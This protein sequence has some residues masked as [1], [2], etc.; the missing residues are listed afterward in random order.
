MS[1]DLLAD[2]PQDEGRHDEMFAAPLEPRAHWQPILQ[3]LA[4]EPAERMR[5]RL[6]TVQRRIRENGV[7]Y[8][9][10][11]DPKGADRPWELDLLPLIISQEEWSGIEAAIA[12]RATLLNAILLDVYGEQRM[13]KEGLL[14]PALVHGHAGFLRPCHRAKQPGGV[15]LHVYAADLARSPDGRW[16]V[17]DDRTQAPSGA[18]YALEN[19]IVISRAFPELFRDL[20]IQ[21]LAS[22]FATLRDSLAHWAPRDATGGALTVLL[23][24]GPLNETYFEHAYLARYLGLPLVEGGDLTVR[25]GCV[26]LKTL[27]GLKRVHAILRR[28]DDDHCDPL[29]LRADSAIGVPGM[30]DAMRRGN[31]LIANALGSNLLESSALLGFLPRLCDRLLGEGLKMPSVATWWCGEPVALKT[32]ADNLERLVVKPAFPQLR[33]EPMFGEDLDERGRRRVTAMLRARPNDYVAQ[34]IVRVSQAPVLDRSHHRRLLAR[35]IGLRVFACASPNGYVVMPGGLT[36]VASAGDARTISMQR[37]GSSKDTWVMAAGPVSTFSL[38]RRSIGPEE[39]VRAGTN[40]SS[41]VV[42]N[43]FWFG[44]YC[45]RCDALARLLRVALGMLVDEMPGDDERVRPIVIELLRQAGILPADEPDPDDVVLAR[46]L[47]AAVSD[48]TRPGLASGLRTLARTASHLRERLSLDNWRT[49]NRMTRGL[50][51]QKGQPRALA[52]LLGELDITIGQFTTL[53]GYAL[54]GMTRDPGWRFLS[55]GRRIERLQSLGA[56]LQQALAN[57]QEIELT[58]LLRL[59]D[60]I[61]TYRARYM[62]RPE[63]LPVLDL[64]VRDEANPRSIAFQ[65]FGLRDFVRRLVEL[66][67]EFGDERFLGPAADLQAIDPAADLKHGSEK[68][69]ALLGEWHDASSRLAEQIGL[70]FFSHVGESSRQTFAT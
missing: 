46:T 37:G 48:E 11:A 20:K 67:G 14:P 3:Q 24:P 1:R 8:N 69:A 2:Y 68:L 44:R 25:D 13:L 65:V 19:R 36:R 58:W 55:I 33:V 10:Y 28:L 41:R 61:I 34:E 63:W 7:T 21:H 32:V 31:V 66:F 40:L 6:Q 16:W 51:S 30:V 5:E 45:E 26:W 60:S 23:T 57:P 42:E 9:V 70:R 64:L 47:R 18:G 50:A 27:S 54:D 15:M 22:F 59:S 53:S 35:A 12:Q 52:D 39:L 43:L 62:S 49:L 56:I 38:L 29:E 4:D 17:I